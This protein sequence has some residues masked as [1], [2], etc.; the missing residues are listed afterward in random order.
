MINF[1]YHIVSITAVFLA[2]AI[3]TALGS[4]FLDGPTV[5][6]L[7]RNIRNAEDRIEATNLENSRLTDLNDAARERE[8]SLLDAASSRLVSNLL[9]DQ[10]VLVLIAPGV[11]A[12][13]AAGVTQMI[14]SSDADHRGTV[15]MLEPMQFTGELDED[16]AAD[17]DLDVTSQAEL[18]DE[19]HELL[20]EAMHTAGQVSPE[21]GTEPSNG[22]DEAPDDLQP[23]DLTPD[24][25][26]DDD[27]ADQGEDDG[28]GDEPDGGPA[29]GEVDG[30][31]DGPPYGG[32]LDGT[33]PEI[34]TALV[35]HGYLALDQPSDAPEAVL[36]VEGYRYVLVSDEGLDPN[37]HDAPLRLVSDEDRTLPLVVVAP[38]P[39]PE[40]EDPDAPMGGLVG[41]I[42][43]DSDLE[44]RVS[45]IDG[46]DTFS[47]LVAMMLV[48]EDMHVSAPG[49]YGQA[50]G[51]VS[52]VP[53]PQ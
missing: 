47:G 35:E 52:V 5:D 23:D 33:Q 13:A 15:A 46:I 8:E 24:G 25:G 11:D 26:T 51:A 9:T 53:T 30:T 17:L 31:G 29:T 34:V 45:T 3:G 40:P 49:H 20:L 36:E 2:L 21:S 22:P 38:T 48:L 18:G 28:T 42:R 39:D 50:E 1:R 44:D 41:L 10:P 37:Q 6:L 12:D 43:Q 19:V 14:A 4:T 16:L 7:N 27:H 32:G